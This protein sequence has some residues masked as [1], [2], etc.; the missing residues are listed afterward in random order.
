MGRVNERLVSSVAGRR[1]GIGALVNQ[2]ICG[3]AKAVL[4]EMP[5]ES[6]HLAITSPPYWNVVDYGVN[7]QIG[8]SSYEEYISDLLEVW[9]ETA[10][11]LCPN[12]KLCINTPIMPIRKCVINRSHTR[13]IK[14]INNDIEASILNDPDCPLERF[15]LYV[16]QKQTSEKMFGSYPYPPNIYED[17]TIE[18]IN[19]FVKDGKPRKLARAIKDASKLTQEEWVNLT[20]QLWPLYPEDVARSGGHPAPF[21]LELPAR[22]I[23]MYAFRRV[24]AERFPGDIVVDMFCGTGATCMAAKAMGRRYIGIDI[25]PGY[26][27][28]ARHR[29]EPRRFPKPNLLLKRVKVRKRSAFR[30]KGQPLL[31]EE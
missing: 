14:N 7:R 20:M 17:N 15:S 31:S 23:A 25:H 11:V 1:K 27:D 3:D 5:D 26:C 16:W 28:M 22:L 13:H 9:R 21:P 19:V 30:Q 29:L 6:V 24:P 4:R 12:G 8:Q 10:R 18:F 2:I